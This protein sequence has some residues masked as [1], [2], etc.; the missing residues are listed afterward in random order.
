MILATTLLVMLCVC[1]LGIFGIRGCRSSG[2]SL[3]DAGV[4]TLVFPPQSK[5]Q[6]SG[7]PRN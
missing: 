3:P 5:F 6:T 7:F 2:D 4:S 1:I